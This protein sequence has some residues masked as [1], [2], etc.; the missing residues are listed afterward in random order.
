MEEKRASLSGTTMVEV[1][2]EFGGVVTYSTE[3]TNR[4]F[5]TGAMRKVSLEE[6]REVI[7]QDGHSAIF[8]EG[9]LVIKDNRV[10]DDLGLSPFG[11]YDLNED[12]LKKLYSTG[13][14]LELEGFLQ[15]CSEANLEKAV[16]VAVEL[17]L[18]DLNRAN[19]IYAYSG[20][21]VLDLIQEA[22]EEEVA[23]TGV[24]QRIDGRA[25]A[26]P[27]TPARGKVVPKN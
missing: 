16:R 25:P 21:N 1:Y 26:N 2:N 10:R 22:K 7:V 17:P 12:D 19:L 23:E 13:D 18:K 6:L 8:E 9:Y 27:T 5:N 14:E 20:I 15:F 11:D 24:R 3:K 4:I